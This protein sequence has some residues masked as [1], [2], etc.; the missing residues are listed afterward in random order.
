MDLPLEQ[1]TKKGNGKIPN[2]SSIVPEFGNFSQDQWI[3]SEIQF[4]TWHRDN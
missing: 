4:N 1:K 2:A 3:V